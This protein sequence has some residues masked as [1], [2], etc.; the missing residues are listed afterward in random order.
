MGTVFTCSIDDGHPSDMKMARLLD[1]HGMQGT[2]YIPIRNREGFAVMQPRQ[3]RDLA[4]RFEVGSH[5]YDH[6]F[7]KY[8]ELTDSHYQ[9]TEGKK[10][11]EDILGERVKGFCYPGGKYRPQDVEIVRAAGFRYARTTVNLCFDTG[12]KPYEMPTTCQIYPHQRGVYWRNFARAGDWK[13]RH[14]GLRVAVRHED[15]I[16]RLYALFD[17]ACLHGRVFHLWGHSQDIDRF[18]AWEEMDSFLEYVSSRIPRHNRLSNAELA[19]R[20][21]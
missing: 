5:T 12:R 16:Q 8:M 15:W 21:Y 1:K 6:C 10:Q 14:A 7:L 19:E 9:V 20:Y 2:F 3:I 11:L 17:Y 18:D 13:E 4:Q